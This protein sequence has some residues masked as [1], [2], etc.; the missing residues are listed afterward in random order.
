MAAAR[1][2]YNNASVRH[3]EIAWRK[4]S[5]GIVTSAGYHAR[6]SMAAAAFA[7]RKS[8]SRQ[9]QWRM[10]IRGAYVQ[11]MYAFIFLGASLRYGGIKIYTLLA[12]QRGT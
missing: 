2:K 7:Q 4:P 11:K 3:D 10:K 12:K 8:A 1:K 9:A 6:L 5:G